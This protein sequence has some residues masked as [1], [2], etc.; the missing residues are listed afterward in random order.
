MADAYD[1]MPASVL[2][3][4]FPVY[5]RLRS[6]DPVHWSESYGGWLLQLL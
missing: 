6:D 1:L 4:P 2:A 5:R 3:D